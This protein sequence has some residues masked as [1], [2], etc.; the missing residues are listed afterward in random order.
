M[1]AKEQDLVDSFV[2]RLSE[3]EPWKRIEYSTE[4]NY[5]RGKTDIVVVSDKNEVIAIEAKLNKWRSAL[6]QAYRNLC[7]ADKSY[8][9]LPPD[10]AEIACSHEYDFNIRGIGICSIYENRIVVVKEASQNKPFQGWLKEQAFQYVL[11]G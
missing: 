11:G 2:E 10:V 5:M 1:Y 3:D 9:L 4:F 8:I 6:H 7:F